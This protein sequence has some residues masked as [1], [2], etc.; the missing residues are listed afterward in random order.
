MQFMLIPCVYILVIKIFIEVQWLKVTR[1]VIVLTDLLLM[2]F[3]NLFYEV[4]LDRPPGYKNF[5][6]TESILSKK[7]KKSVLK[8]IT[9][10]I[11]DNESQDLSFN[12][13]TLTFTLQMVKI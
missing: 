7:V 11:E 6:P 4:V 5:F 10:Y 9:F 3:N 1:N 12:Q 8:T 13:K 2:A